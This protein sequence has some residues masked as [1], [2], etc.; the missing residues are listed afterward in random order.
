[1]DKII[2]TLSP[3]T[4]STYYVLLTLQQP[5][6]GY[7]IIKQV[8]EMTSGRL[9]LAAGT[10]YGVLQNLVKYKCIKLFSKEEVGKKKKE[11]VITETGKQLLE[12]EVKRLEQMVYDAKQGGAI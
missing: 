9:Q 2:K 12:Y 1:M 4:E 3:L 10:L 5:L 6:H 11:Y 8:E 7:G